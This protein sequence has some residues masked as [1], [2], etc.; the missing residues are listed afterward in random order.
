MKKTPGIT[1]LIIASILSLFVMVAPRHAEAGVVKGIVLYIPNRVFDILDI[2]RVR[3]RVGPGISV[4]ARVTEAADV[5]VGGHATAWVGLRG[6]RGKP[7]IPWP[8]G[9]ENIG[10]VEV[11]FADATKTNRYTDPL[12]LGLEAQ[13]AVI[14]INFGIELYEML[15]LVTGFVFIDLQ[16]DDF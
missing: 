10:G 8:F 1:L 13:A 3:L 15:D 4:G 14:G 5:F 9:L 11:S 16:K 12:E 2:L 6:A 7:Q